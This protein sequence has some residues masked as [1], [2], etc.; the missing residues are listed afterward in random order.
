MRKGPHV[1]GNRAPHASLT[2]AL[3]IG[4]RRRRTPALS[5]ARGR[6]AAR[7]RTV[8][9]PGESDSHGE[10]GA[11]VPVGV[12]TCTILPVDGVCPK[13]AHTPAGCRHRP[14]V[15]RG[16]ACATTARRQGRQRAGHPRR[17]SPLRAMPAN[18][19]QGLQG[20]GARGAR[21]P[22][23]CTPRDRAGA[24]ARSRG[25]TREARECAVR[26]PMVCVFDVLGVR[27]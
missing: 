21:T 20:A 7:T 24:R 12:R 18:A 13:L 17:C 14:A 22:G 6:K 16:M 23:P 5:G 27:A 9:V 1:Q 19:N 3:A 10:P 4:T 26:A 8:P 2:D 15:G 25:S 11:H